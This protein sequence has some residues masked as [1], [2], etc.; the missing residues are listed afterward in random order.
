MNYPP[1]SP[2]D[3]H[4][5]CIINVEQDSGAVTV[6]GK[7]NKIHSTDVKR[8][9]VIKNVCSAGGGVV[10]LPISYDQ[11][12]SWLDFASNSTAAPEEM[13]PGQLTNILLVLHPLTF[14]P[15]PA[16]CAVH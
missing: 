8:S 2:Q 13:P 12:E 9:D 10:P 16:W 7:P 4:D 6:Q 14:I 5:V 15:M 11:F 3:C 1:Y